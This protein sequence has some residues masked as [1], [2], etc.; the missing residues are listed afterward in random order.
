[1]LLCARRIGGD[2][3]ESV[4]IL[5]SKAIRGVA[6]GVVVTALTQ[7]VLGGIGL[8]VAGVPYAA[9]F[10]AAMFMLAVAQIG[11]GPVM[12][13]AVIWLFWKGETGWGTALLVWSV[14]VMVLDNVLRPML[15]KRGVDLPMLLILVGVIGGLIGF[16]LVG[17]FVGPIV[18]AVTYTLVAA[19][20]AEAPRSVS[21]G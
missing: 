16:G 9:V 10:T 7:A 3:G 4:V 5:A 17:I 2:R 8:A 13:C 12:I 15:I 19:W 1:V 6:I 20:S 11:V 14:L 18:L 21:D